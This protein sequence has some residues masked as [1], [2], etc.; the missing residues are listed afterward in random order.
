MR[1]SLLLALLLGLAAPSVR[2]ASSAD[3]VTFLPAAALDAAF[4]KGQP[5]TENPEFKVHAS[6]RTGPGQVEVHRRDTDVIHVLEGSATLVTGGRALEL[7]EVAPDELRGRAIEGGDER[8]LARGDLVIVPRGVPHW[9]REASAPFLYYVV[10]VS[11]EPRDPDAAPADS[12][13]ATIDLSTREGVALVHGQWRYGDARIVETRHRAPGVDGDPTGAP[14]RTSETLPRAGEAEFDDSGFEKVDPTTL[15]RRRGTGR[16]CFGWYRIGV[17]IPERI[18]AFDPSGSTVVFQTTADDYAEV[19]VDG[20]LPRALG[21]RGGSVVAGWNAPNRLVIARN[22]RP[23]Q[24]IVL[25]V[26]AANGPLSDPPA[27]FLW[28]REARLEFL[29]GQGAEPF[30]SEPSELNLGIERTDPGLDTVLPPNPKLWRLAEGFQFT[31]GPV[32]T[33]DGLLLS[34]PNANRIYRY[35]PEGRLSVFRE[36][37]GY[38]GADIAEYRQPGSNGLALDPQGR[39]T[40]DQ[41]GRRRVVRLEAD[42]TETVLA[43]RYEGRRL[44]SPNDLVWRSDGTLFFTDPPFGL[45]GFAA[46]P[47]KE[48]A[49]SGVFAWKDNRLRLLTRELAGPNGIAFSPDERFLYVGDWDEQHKVVMRWA[50][51][52]DGTLSGG[53][54]F[55]DM[56]RAPGEDAIDGIKVDRAGNLFVSGP[57][58]LWVLSPDGRH[59]GTLRTP[60]HV[61]NLAWGDPDGRTLYL[62]A[63]SE[64]YRLRVLTGRAERSAAGLR[65]S[66]EP[67][68]GEGVR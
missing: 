53:R 21:Q 28:L 45:P 60:K 36:K 35:T 65:A 6:R 62:A 67:P 31:E 25:A 42:G 55:F 46:D 20:E 7:S 26:F 34:D 59:L 39:L 66:A 40:I 37:S 24:R 43:E 13:L 38:D 14:V 18:G 22:A 15:G 23:G 41:H 58:G 11:G 8:R 5:L 19:W 9:F 30:A 64:L 1:R 54:V 32:W 57:G 51:A 3:S 52:M 47:R 48:L 17:T 63:G 68:A 16:L 4:A 56:T 49:W 10:K 33:G 44:N 12:P 29:P 27:N 50:V 2:A 61:H